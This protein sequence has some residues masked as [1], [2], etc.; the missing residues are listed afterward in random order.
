MLMGILTMA[1]VG[2]PVG[3]LLV[4][5]WPALGWYLRR[6]GRVF[7]WIAPHTISVVWFVIRWLMWGIRVAVAWLFWAVR[8]AS[9]LFW[10]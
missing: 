8:I 6:L 9:R 10:G 1:L 7:K 4:V 5:L 3:L 2:G